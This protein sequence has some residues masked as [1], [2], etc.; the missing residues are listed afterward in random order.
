MEN[1]LGKR[2]RRTKEE[3]EHDESKVCHIDKL[4]YEQVSRVPVKGEIFILNERFKMSKKGAERMSA[5]RR[6]CFR[7][8][9][10]T[11]KRLLIC[12]EYRKEGITRIVSFPRNDF[13]AGIMHV[14]V[15][16]RVYYSSGK[17]GL[18]WE[19]LAVENF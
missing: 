17:N 1:A 6:G 2:I 12:E 13:Y 9:D 11:H 8:I 10:D 4:T 14:K 18:S 15:V 3:L 19:Q 5:E 16:D 7:V